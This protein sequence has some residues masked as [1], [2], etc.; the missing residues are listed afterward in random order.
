MKKLMKNSNRS[1]ILILLL[2]LCLCMLTG[3]QSTDKNDSY[4]KMSGNGATQFEYSN[5]TDKTKIIW[6]GSL[7]NNTVYNFNSFS[8]TFALYN[9]SALV[10]TATYNYNQRVKHGEYYIGQFSFSVDGKVDSI[11][12]VSWTANYDTF[13]NTYKIW[14]IITIALV[15]V[16]S[17]IYIIVMIIQDLELYDV[18]EF[19]SENWWIFFCLLL[20]LAFGI[21]G[22][23]V[24]YWIPVLIV[25]GG[26]L[27]FIVVSLLAHL[28]K[29]IIQSI[30]S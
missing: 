20:P 9:D 8:V 14:I 5:N 16:A 27:S 18:G 29:F 13:W 3:C 28:I 30:I 26:I 23:V 15:G 10:D 6:S 2:I 7:T 12:Y 17:L 25:L 11:E 4:L 21:W 1:A 24:S 19:L 22:I